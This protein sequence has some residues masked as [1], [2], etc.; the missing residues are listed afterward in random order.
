MEGVPLSLALQVIAIA[1]LSARD[2]PECGQAVARDLADLAPLVRPIARPRQRR[3]W[4]KDL[5]TRRPHAMK[6]PLSA[7]RRRALRLYALG[8]GLVLAGAATMSWTQSTV[9]MALAGAAAL[10]LTVP[11]VRDLAQGRR[12]RG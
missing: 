4:R 9:P 3:D 1:S 5:P 12:T 11:I 10:M 6:P 8:Q 7:S 2:G